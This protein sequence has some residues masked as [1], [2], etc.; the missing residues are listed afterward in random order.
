MEGR[1]FT[2]LIDHM[3]D[4][5]DNKENVKPTRYAAPTRVEP[6][7]SM[8]QEVMRPSSKSGTRVQDKVRTLSLT[9]QPDQFVFNQQYYLNRLAQVSIVMARVT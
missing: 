3:Q 8:N 7:P 5:S 1:Q 6:I 9:N 4:S 2:I